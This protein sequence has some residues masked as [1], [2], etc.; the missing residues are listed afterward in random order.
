[1]FKAIDQINEVKASTKKANDASQKVVKK[2]DDLIKETKHTYDSFSDAE[3]IV[4]KVENI[5]RKLETNQ[6]VSN[7]E[8]L[9]K[10]IEELEK[11]LKEEFENKFKK[12][13]IAEE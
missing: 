8:K 6:F 11:E 10:D 1:M 3:K 7:F 13:I 2:I 5:F 12:I 4:D 9:K